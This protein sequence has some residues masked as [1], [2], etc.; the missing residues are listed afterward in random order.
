M[1]ITT[2]NYPKSSFLSLEKDMKILVDNIMENNRLK[3]LLYYTTKDCLNKPNLTEDQTLELFGNQIK[4]IPKFKIDHTVLNYL[5]ISFDNFMTNYS[6]PEFRDNTISFD[7]ICHLDQ[8]QLNDFELRPYRIAAEIDSLLS[9][10]SLT[11]FGSLE[12]VGATKILLTDEFAGLS[13][14][15]RA[16]HGEEDKKHMPNP[17]KEEQFIKD[18][19]ELYN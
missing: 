16:I 9:Q 3:K 6:N 12:F 7:I 2:Y 15:Y 19:N 10:K 8:W 1:K 5:V 4:I 18:F 13:L 17:A 11:N 14:M